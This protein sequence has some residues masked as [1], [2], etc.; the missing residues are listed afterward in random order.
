MCLTEN[1]MNLKKKKGKK[2][3]KKRQLKILIVFIF[4][5]YPSISFISHCFVIGAWS[6]GLEKKEKEKKTWGI[7]FKS[8]DA[9]T[10]DVKL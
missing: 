2:E 4:L 1:S 10:F 8:F 7:P 6:D 9:S 3:K 5:V